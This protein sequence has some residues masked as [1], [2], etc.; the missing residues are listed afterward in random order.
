M[1]FMDILN[2]ILAIV[3]GLGT[4]IPLLIQL[5]KYIK[6]AA[7]SKNWSVLM[8]LVL[9]F[10]T[11]AEKLFATGAERKE[12]VMSKIK[13]MEKTLNCDVDE[14]VVSS[15]IDSIVRASKTINAKKK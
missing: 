1:E 9:E 12:Y 13:E 14:D 4:A 5:V 10:M 7:K 2:L 6:E 8:T 15:M 3:A 11:D